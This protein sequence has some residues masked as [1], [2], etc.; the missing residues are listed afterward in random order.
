MRITT[1][2]VTYF[3]LL[4]LL[5]RTVALFDLRNGHSGLHSWVCSCV[6][7]TTQAT[8]IRSLPVRQL[9]A[10]AEIHAVVSATVRENT[11]SNVKTLP[12]TVRTRPSTVRIG[13]FDA[14]HATFE[15][16]WHHN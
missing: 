6:V 9:N 1:S 8:A 12:D 14:L 16:N 10:N 15:I 2:P 11:I 4:H 5:C 13:I 7:A 3:R